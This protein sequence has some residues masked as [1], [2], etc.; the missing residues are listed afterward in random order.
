MAIIQNLSYTTNI[1]Y[2][3]NLL[4]AFQRSFQDYDK[5]CVQ[6]KL[7]KNKKEWVEAFWKEERAIQGTW[8]NY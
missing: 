8:L 4:I 2:K 7:V 5:V 1:I 3:L 6:K